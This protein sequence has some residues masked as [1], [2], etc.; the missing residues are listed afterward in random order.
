M[1]IAPTEEKLYKM[2]AADTSGRV[3]PG[4]ELIIKDMITGAEQKVITSEVGTFEF[5]LR[6]GWY[7][8]IYYADKRFYYDSLTEL[9]NGNMRFNGK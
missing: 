4:E 7:Y 1:K 6:G 2:T 8:R 5:A 9:N 3:F